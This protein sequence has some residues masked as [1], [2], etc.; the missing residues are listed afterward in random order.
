MAFDFE[1]IYKRYSEFWNLENHDR[2][3]CVF[4]APKKGT[5]APPPTAP[6][7]L[8]DRW[9]DIEY[10][11]K[12]F[13]WSMNTVDYLGEGY[14]LFNPNLGPDLVGAVCGC[15]LNFG[16]V[17]SWAT[18]CI[19]DYET[20]PPIVFDENNFWWKQ[21]S[22]MTKAA[23]ED[24][25]GEFIVGISDLHPG[26][27]AMV[28]M[29]GAENAA[30][31][32]YDE[33]EQFVRRNWEV[34]EVF[35]EMTQRLYNIV[36]PYQRGCSNWMG[37]LHPDDMWYVTSCDFAYMISSDHFDEFILP[38]LKA[39]L[40]WL[41]ASIFHLDGI[42]SLKHLDRLLELEKLKGIQWVYGVGQPSGMH[43][44]DVY[45]KI[46]AA[47]KSIEL[48]CEMKDVIPLCEV[49]NPEGV[50]INCSIP[51]KESGEALIRDLERLYRQKRGVFPMV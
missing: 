46:Q 1:P 37:V 4:I 20:H 7:N 15:D 28:S 49:L 38:E 11:L 14:P 31:D 17:T 34:F 19:E 50:R 41:P 6:T 42:G 2:P 13:R 33:P 5:F 45:K 12:A 43:W 35:K 39:E 24:A 10:Q 21:V 22:E 8:R 48:L 26:G 30:M 27:D 25:N 18:P 51:D 23:A 3:L 32:L 9:L 36:S 44:I 16:E 29:R 40:D 47:G